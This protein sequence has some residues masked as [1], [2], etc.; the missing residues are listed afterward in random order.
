[1]A[2]VLVVVALASGGSDE[3]S[4]KIVWAAAPLVQTPQYL[5]RDRVL[6]A[7]I[8]ND[9]LQDVDLT[10]ADIRIVDPDGRALKSTARFL[11]GYAHGLFS[12]LQ[13]PK[14]PNPNEQRQ[15]GEIATI[16]PGQKA[17]L[18]LSWRV[19][20]GGKQPVR[21]DIGVANDLDI[22]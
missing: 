15:L 13:R 3:A 5:P 21:V 16:K 8:R 18:T 12:P 7:Q 22:P 20:P 9:S 17:P 6:V 11:R 1:M 14:T 19:P 10:A 4:A 2:G